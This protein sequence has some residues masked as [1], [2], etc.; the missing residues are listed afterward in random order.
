LIAKDGEPPCCCCRCCCRCC[1]MT[2]AGMLTAALAHL[3]DH[4]SV[5]TAHRLHAMCHTKCGRLLE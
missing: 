1:W 4:S 2:L 3:A 5:V